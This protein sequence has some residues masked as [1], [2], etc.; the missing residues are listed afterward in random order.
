MGSSSESVPLLPPA[1]G[2]WFE[3]DPVGRRKFFE[4]GPLAL[5]AGGELDQFTLAYETWG[6]LSEDG[7]NA[8]L[9]LH[10]L[11]GDSH[12]SGETGPGHPTA[13]WW[14]D[15]IGAGAPIDTERYFVVAPNILG[16]CQGS[17]GPASLREG[18]SSPDTSSSLPGASSSLPVGSPTQA[19]WGG[20]FPFVTIRDTV[21]AEAQL[22]DELGIDTWQ[23]VIGGSLG[24]MRALEW[25]AMFPGRVAKLVPVA[26]TAAT[27]ADQIAGLTPSWRQSSV[28]RGSTAGTTMVPRRARAP[29]RAWGLPAKSR[30]PRTV[31]RLSLR[32]G[33][34]QTRKGERTLGREGATPSSPTC[35]T[36]VASLSIALMPTH[37]RF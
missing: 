6:K 4:G 35:S 3:T 7:S 8:V 1:S 28:I 11:T 24:G 12:L 27:T 32:P 26:T 20:D 19:R 29:R 14:T 36:R 25:A 30:T 10:A 34:A 22:A 37:T 31:A 13:G 21:A 23:M 5:E 2:A 18:V 16:G 17:T 15:L 9:I 33:S